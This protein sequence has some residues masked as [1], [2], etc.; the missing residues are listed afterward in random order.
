MVDFAFAPLPDG[1]NGRSYPLPEGRAGLELDHDLC[2]VGRRATLGHE[3]VHV[4]RRIWFP[5]GTPAALVAKEEAAVNV[6][7]A[8]RMVPPGELAL[9]VASI[10]QFEAVT[11]QVVAEEFDVTEVVA[12]R[13]LRLLR[14][15][16]TA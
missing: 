8:R 2:R 12:C 13:A 5:P 15:D 7:V 16:L 14:A 3:L 9:F 11:A 4:E 6:E 1:V 10:S